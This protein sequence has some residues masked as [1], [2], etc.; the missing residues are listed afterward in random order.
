MAAIAII[1]IGLTTSFSVLYRARALERGIEEAELR[2]HIAERIMERTLAL[3]LEDATSRSIDLAPADA[4][5]RRGWSAEVRIQ[6]RGARLRYIGVIVRGGGG[7]TELATLQSPG[8]A[9]G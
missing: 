5:G 6:A 1:G 3:G 8:T 9:A 2:A 7:T 4:G